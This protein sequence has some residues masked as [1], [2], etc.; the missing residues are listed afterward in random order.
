MFAANA[1]WCLPAAIT[2]NMLRAASTLTGAA[3]YAVARG[4][5]LRTHLINIPARLARP[6][7]RPILHLPAHWPRVATWLTLWKAV[8]T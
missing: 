8:F 6:Q 3:R 5:T 7:Q 1:A 4:A 2:H